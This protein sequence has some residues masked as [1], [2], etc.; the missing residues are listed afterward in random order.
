MAVEILRPQSDDSYERISFQALEGGPEE[1]SLISGTV[2]WCQGQDNRVVFLVWEGP[3]FAAHGHDLHDAF[4]KARA[5]IEARGFRPL[6]AGVRAR[7]PADPLALFEPADI[8]EI[9][10]LAD[11][12]DSAAEVTAPR[13]EPKLWVVVALILLALLVPA[14]ARAEVPVSGLL[15]QFPNA[16]FSWRFEGSQPDAHIVVLDNGTGQAVA[17]HEIDGGSFCK[18]DDD[19][20]DLDG[21]FPIVLASAPQDPVLGVVAHVGAHGQRISVFRPLRD[22]AKPVFE[23][24]AEYALILKVMPDGLAVEMEMLGTADQI[25][26][27]HRMWIAG[28]TGQC[29]AATAPHLPEP[30]APSAEAAGLEN[31]LRRIARERNLYDFVSLLSDD[32]LVSFGG[33]GGKQ[34]FLSSLDQGHETN[35]EAAFWKSLDRLLAAGGWNESAAPQSMIWPWFFH[36]WPDD[37]DGYDAYIV[38]PDIPLRAGPDDTAPVLATLGFGVLRYAAPDWETEAVDWQATGWLPVAAPGHC[39]GYVRAEDATPLL[40]TRL[41][42]RQTSSGWKIEALVEGD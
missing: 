27:D 12:E 29:A 13:F 6:V 39:L 9:A 34:E 36:A 4:R 32:V 28:D 19:N 31:N 42:A 5:G 26:R 7:I 1:K 3:S 15:A 30:P 41:V 2:G 35:G 18:G 8:A 14:L 38:G 40:G 10:P 23:A 20:C 21:I 11:A 37:D 17:R 25:V 33:D 16:P 24:V 22:K